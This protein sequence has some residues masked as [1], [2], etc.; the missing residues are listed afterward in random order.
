MERPIESSSSAKPPVSKALRPRIFPRTQEKLETSDLTP[1][2]RSQS[3]SD[4]LGQR[5]EFRAAHTPLIY[6]SG[7]S[8]LLD[9]PSW[10]TIF[11]DPLPT[12]DFN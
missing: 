2:P 5:S 10:L 9:K 11:V 1:A 3:L 7:L 4:S 8:F 12:P 6:H